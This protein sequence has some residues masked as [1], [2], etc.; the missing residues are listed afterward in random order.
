VQVGVQ[1]GLD[2]RKITKEKNKLS[3]GKARAPSSVVMG[4]GVGL[5]RQ[6]AESP[7]LRG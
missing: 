5:G 4:F 1:I 2:D 7:I 3:R 6:I